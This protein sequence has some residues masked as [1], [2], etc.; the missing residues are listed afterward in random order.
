[1]I[2]KSIIF[3]SLFIIVISILVC[4]FTPSKKILLRTKVDYLL[5]LKSERRLIAYSSN[6]II[7]TYKIALGKSPIG[8][9]EFEGDSKT[10]EG[11]YTINAKSDTSK[12][13]KNLGISY[14]DSSDIEKSK[15]YGKPTGGDIK[16]H[17]LRNGIGFIG[18]LHRL[19]DWTAGCIA[20]TNDEIEELYQAV[21]IGTKIEIRK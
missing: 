1:M 7:K 6:Q 15:Q 20:V 4:Y 12:F 21:E 16:I 19:V 10:P 9:K 11:F 17:G 5:V 8:D 14:P 13:Y 2:F 18:K 3:I